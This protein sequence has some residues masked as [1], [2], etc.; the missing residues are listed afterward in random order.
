MQN[1]K[2]MNNDFNNLIANLQSDDNTTIAN[3]AERSAERFGDAVRTLDA[4]GDVSR[5]AYEDNASELIDEARRD[6]AKEVV[7]AFEEALRDGDWDSSFVTL[8]DRVDTAVTAQLVDL[9]DRIVANENI[10]A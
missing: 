2:A 5:L 6:E 9:C 10:S 7:A 1:S 4:E 3:A 8:I